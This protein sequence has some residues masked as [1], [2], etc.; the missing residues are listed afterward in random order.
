MSKG[1][2]RK[3][4]RHLEKQNLAGWKADQCKISVFLYKFHCYHFIFFYFELQYRCWQWRGAAGAAHVRRGWRCT[5]A[6]T[7]GT[8]EPLSPT[9]GA[10]RQVHLRKGRKQERNS[11]GNIKVRRR[12]CCSVVSEQAF[13]AGFEGPA[14][15]KGNGSG[16]LLW[17]DCNSCSPCC[18]RDRMGTEEVDKQR[19]CV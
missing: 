17:T 18:V 5:S 19:S 14:L 1:L 3:Y 16:E 6:P 9:S 13:P 12:R 10:S 4:I 2:F 8:A 7:V 11:R 15:S